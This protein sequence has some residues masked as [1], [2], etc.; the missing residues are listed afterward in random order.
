MHELKV[1]AVKENVQ[2]LEVMGTSPSVPK[3][4]FL[5]DDYGKYDKQLKDY[6]K[7]EIMKMFKTHW[8]KFSI[9]SK[10]AQRILLKPISTL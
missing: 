1:R 10:R 9:Y 6:V 8:M 7:K 4:C 5:K 2:Y 3:D